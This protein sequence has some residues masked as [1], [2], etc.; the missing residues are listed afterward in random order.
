[1][2]TIIL[3]GGIGT[4]LAEETVVIPKPMVE[5]GGHPILYHILSLYAAHGH[6]DFIIACGYKGELIKDYF[7]HY[8]RRNS[9][10]LVDIGKGIVQELSA[11]APDWRVNLV[12]TGLKTQTGGR[13]KRCMP[14]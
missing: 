5:I 3:A 12:D 9:D 4:R 11:R 13:V 2:K 6:K 10:L 7:C 8:R 14:L 1:M